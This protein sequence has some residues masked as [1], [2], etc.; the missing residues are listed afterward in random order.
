MRDIHFAAHAH[1]VGWVKRDVGTIYGGFAYLNAPQH[2]EIVR[3]L[4]NPTR[5]V[6]DRLEYEIQQSTIQRW[7]L[8]LH[9]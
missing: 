7:N 8:F 5:L 6:A 1:I 9:T 2:F 4:A 3:K